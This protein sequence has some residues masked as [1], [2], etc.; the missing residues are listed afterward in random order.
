MSKRLI[1]LCLVLA[2]LTSLCTACLKPTDNE[3]NGDELN[4]KDNEGEVTKDKDEGE[5][6]LDNVPDYMEATGYPI[7]K[8]EITIRALGRRDATSPE[9]NE[10]V[11]FQKVEEL[12][13]IRFEFEL[14]E[15][16]AIYNEK[17]N[18][19]F[20]TGNYPDVFMRSAVT[21]REEEK[22]GPEG[23]FIDLKPYID[24]YAPNL[25]KRMAEHPE[26]ESAITAMDGNIYGLPAYIR[27]STQNPWICYMNA[28]WLDRV[29]KTMPETVDDFYELLKAY[30]TQDAN[31]NGDPNDEI[32]F[33]GTGLGPFNF[34]LASF[35]GLAGGMTFDVKEDGTVVYTP[36]IPEF[37][38]FLIFANRLY[39]EELVD[40]EI[41]SQSGED[42]QKK[43]QSGIVGIY[44]VSPTSLPAE[45]TDRQD[46]LEPLTS[47]F[48][49][50]KVAP[51]Y[52]AVIPG[53]AVITNQC[54]YPEALM[55]WFDIWYAKEDE[56]VEGLDGNA[57]FLG[58]KDEHWEYADPK[59]E[60][61]RWIEPVTS[62]QTLRNENK[63]TENTGLPE[64]LNF[65]PY[66]ADFP[67]MEMKV[68]AT[69]TRQEPYMI[70]TYPRTARYE[71]EIFER[72]AELEGE[73]N[74]Y[75][76]QTVIKFIT[77][78]EPIENYDNFVSTIQGMGIDELKEI[79]QDGYNRWAGT[80]K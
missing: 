42:N 21:I 16:A 40:P 56:G 76:N 24:D 26:I 31:G 72:I 17:K 71:D 69:Q 48:N 18:L 27:T 36:L 64:Y 20:A 68:K 60:T 37:K 67:L 66:P 46:C 4:S 38:E 70:P 3:P 79:K 75:V 23:V 6:T 54:E 77:G 41:F 44:N 50:K 13:N 45:T 12:T 78:E 32:P 52:Q 51:A 28:E 34:I 55:R 62:F 47:E 61:Y 22:Y 8:E 30:K 57:L 58:F 15:S 63:V 43:A 9:W 39:K 53:A 11:L 59:N 29:G 74:P 35:T 25:K 73:I 7:V 14:A 33:G 65:M 49:D 1:S 5:K 19:A 10:M 80:S 2:L